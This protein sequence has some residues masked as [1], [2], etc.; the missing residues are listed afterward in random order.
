MVVIGGF[1]SK[2]FCDILKRQDVGYT[3]VRPNV[4]GTLAET[5][6]K[7]FRVLKDIDET[8]LSNM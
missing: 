3:L 7:Y 2:G 6:E 4:T 8:T 5:E 1:H